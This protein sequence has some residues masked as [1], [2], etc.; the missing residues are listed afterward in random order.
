MTKL[1]DGVLLRSGEKV[2][3]SGY[4]VYVRHENTEEYKNCFIANKARLGLFLVKGSI[5]P[6]LIACSHKV[7][8]R[9]DN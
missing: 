3:A 5:V 8:W 9:F 2:T 1:E 7:I 4:Y 6:D